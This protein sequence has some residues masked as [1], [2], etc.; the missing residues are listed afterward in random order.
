MPFPYA[1]CGVALRLEQVRN[2]DLIGVEAPL[3]PGEKHA[4]TTYPF[5]ITTGQK[6]SPRG[7]ANRSTRI[8]VGEA[9]ALLGHPVDVRCLDERIAKTTGIRESHVINE[10]EDDVGSGLGGQVEMAANVY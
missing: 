2:G 8:K 3:V 1:G 4:Q 9:H 10:D 6:S 7:G 5:G